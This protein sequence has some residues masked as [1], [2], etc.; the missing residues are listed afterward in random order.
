MKSPVPCSIPLPF[1]SVTATFLIIWVFLSYGCVQQPAPPAPERPPLPE[2]PSSDPLPEPS[3]VPGTGILLH[4]QEEQE[5]SLRMS[6]VTSVPVTKRETPRPSLPATNEKGTLR[7][8]RT[9]VAASAVP[10]ADRLVVVPGSEA[11]DGAGDIYALSPYARLLAQ[12][13]RM[14]SSM[15]PSMRLRPELT[16]Y[17]SVEH[18]PGVAPD[19]QPRH[20]VAQDAIRPAPAEWEKLAREAGEIFGL[21]AALVLAVI[22]A[23]SAFNHAAESPA[24][25]QGAMQVMPG[26]QVELGLIDPFD[27]RANVY[28]GSQYLMELMQRFGSVELALA[29]Y[30]AGPA[31]VEKYGGVP[32][33]PETREFVRRVMAYWE[34][35]KRKNAELLQP[36][37]TQQ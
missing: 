27:P 32:P 24:G 11:A 35:G 26:T 33:F 28:A 23:E 36:S 14:R 7:V 5:I 12:P 13:S 4:E 10:P 6:R 30:N 9:P 31:G 21:D 16:D 15:H 29:A 8:I 17:G 22:R 1:R 2:Y 25:A 34:A 20:M 18:T 37:P 19:G 3:D